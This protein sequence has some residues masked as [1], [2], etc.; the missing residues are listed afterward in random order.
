MNT[1]MI[2]KYKYNRIIQELEILE[3]ALFSLE[4]KQKSISEVIECVHVFKREMDN[5]IKK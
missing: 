4:M 2:N 1:W 3:S 5:L